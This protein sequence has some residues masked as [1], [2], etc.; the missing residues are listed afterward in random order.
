MVDLE[1]FNLDAAARR[2]LVGRILWKG[3][4]YAGVFATMLYLLSPAPP[5]GEL[6][7][8][9]FVDKLGH[10]AIFAV[11]ALLGRRAYPENPAWGIAVALVVLGGAIE[12]AQPRAGRSADVLDLF[13]DAVGASAAFLPFRRR[14]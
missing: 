11:L 8:R 12:Y 5:G 3:A 14:A 4:F 7:E 6:F 9:P 2:A 1:G 13:A 10:V